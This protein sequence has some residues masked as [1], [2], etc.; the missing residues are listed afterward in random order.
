MGTRFVATEEAAAH[1]SYK[2]AICRAAE[3][4][5]VYSTLFDGG[6]PDAPHRT[7]WS[8]TTR[9]WDESGRP[10][11][12]RRPGEGEPIATRPNGDPILRYEDTIPLAG[13]EGDLEALA[14]YAGQSAALVSRVMP[15]GELVTQLAEEAVAVIG[16]LGRG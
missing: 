6:W 16:R 7:L 3:T 1:E 9:R 8:S 11:S 13:M 15:A 2:M 10:P 4:E 12:G 14:L 5:T